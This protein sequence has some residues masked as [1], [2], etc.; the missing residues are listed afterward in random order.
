MAYG[1]G[2]R[3]EGKK[4]IIKVVDIPGARVL[5]TVVV[6]VLLLAIKSPVAQTWVARLIPDS[7]ILTNLRAFLSTYSICQPMAFYFIITVL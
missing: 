7:S 6:H 4:E 1:T 5:G 3:V 2:D